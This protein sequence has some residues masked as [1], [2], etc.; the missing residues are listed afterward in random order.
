MKTTTTATAPQKSFLRTL[1]AREQYKNWLRVID[2][3]LPC[4]ASQAK[5]MIKT[6]Y[7]LG[8]ITPQDAEYLTWYMAQ[9]GCTAKF[10]D[11]KSGRFVRLVNMGDLRK[12]WQAEFSI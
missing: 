7:S 2:T 1:A 12:C 9:Y 4:T 3:L 6:G 8:V 11:T 10:V 5:E